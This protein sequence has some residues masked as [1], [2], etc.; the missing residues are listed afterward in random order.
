MFMTMKKHTVKDWL[1]AVRPWS[2]PASAM[3]VIVTVAYAYWTAH[4]IDWWNGVWALVNIVLFHAAGNTW[5][6]YFDFRKEVDA[7]DTF[8]ATAMTQG[9]FTSKEIFRL[10]CFL[11]A[12]SLLGGL[13]LL[14]R[15]GL[16]LLYIGIGGLLCTL[17]YPVSKY[18]ALGDVVIFLSYALLPT[19]GTFYAVSLAINWS[20]LYVA[21]PVGL[22]TVAILHANNLRDVRTDERAHISTLVIRLGKRWSLFL[23]CVEVLFPFGWLAC[24]IVLDIFPVWAWLAFLALIPAYGNVRLLSRYNPNDTASVSRLDEHTAQLQLFFSLLLA[25]AFFIAG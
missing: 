14:W 17:L 23:Y 15:T 13:G 3:P 1:M 7:A 5:S 8:G 21:V 6:D 18:R 24:C 10:S 16:P 4:S 2:F 9:G 11:L 20:V 25:A 22:I 12:V 19:L